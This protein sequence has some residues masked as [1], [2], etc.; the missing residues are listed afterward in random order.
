VGGLLQA[1]SHQMLAFD[2]SSEL[3]QH[4]TI[5]TL[6]RL[7]LVTVLLSAIVFLG[8]ILFSLFW[9]RTNHKEKLAET[10][11]LLE[12]KDRETLEVM[13]KAQHLERK[14]IAREMHD[15]FGNL[16]ATARIQISQ[17]EAK[18]QQ[19]EVVEAL[20]LTI[21]Q[22]FE[23]VRS[24]SNSLH[25]GLADRFGLTDALVA[26]ADSVQERGGLDIKLVTQID[27]DR[28]EMEQH[29]A[30]YRMA[31]E[32]ITQ[33][34]KHAKAHVV[35][36]QVTTYEDTIHLMAEDDGRSL[37]TGTLEKRSIALKRL[38]AQVAEQGGEM[39]IDSRSGQ[40]TYISIDLPLLEISQL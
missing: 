17:L 24:L 3:E 33:V 11:Y 30:V 29:L 22:A 8:I 18:D 21:G 2:N 23:E 39:G 6:H 28:V 14:Q 27:E 5:K 26:L 38:Q 1:G 40:G 37:P 10:I 16:L 31:Q 20:A 34:L 35:T 4:N 9:A 7:Q 25:V 15:H 12:V 19:S 13:L 32:L 36:L